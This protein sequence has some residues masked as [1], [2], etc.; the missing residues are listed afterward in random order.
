M[1]FPFVS[2]V[3]SGLRNWFISSLHFFGLPTALRAFVPV[4]SAGFHLAA[5]CVD[6]FSGSD[7]ILIASLHFIFLCVSIQHEMLA[8]FIF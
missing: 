2:S 6:L 3:S 8:E 4:L 7:A 5:S 1:S